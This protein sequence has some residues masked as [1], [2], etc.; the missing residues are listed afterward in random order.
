MP[1][2]QYASIQNPRQYRALRRRGFGKSAAARISNA[3]TAG[4]TV[5]APNYGAR[6]GQTIAGNLVRGSDGKFSSGSGGAPTTRQQQAAARRQTRQQRRDQAASA[7]DQAQAQEDTQRARE[8]AYVAGGTTGRERQ[9]RRREVAAARRKRLQARREAARQA[10]D[11]ERQQRSREEAGDAG[12][13]G[14]QVLRDRLAG[15]RQPKGG[16]G[17]GGGGGKKKPTDDEKRAEQLRKRAATA[18]ATAAQVGQDASFVEG[19]RAAAEGRLPANAATPRLSALGFAE[20]GE[21]TD[22]GRRALSALERGDVRGYQAAVQDARSARQRRE[23]TAA[24]RQATD[25]RRRAREHERAVRE[26]QRAVERAA[27]EAERNAR[28]AR[29]PLQVGVTST[30]AAPALPA[31]DRVLD[32]GHTGVM[33]ALFPDPAAVAAIT[34]AEGVTEPADQLHLTLAFLGDST[35]VPLATNKA[36][37]VDAVRSWAQ[38]SWRPLKGQVN[39]AGRFYNAESDGTNAIYLAPDVPGLPE[40]RQSLVAAIEAAGLDYASDHG[41]TPHMTIAYVPAD[42]PTPDV[43]VD[44]PVRFDRVTL[45]WGDE[46]YDFAG[47]AQ[48]AKAASAL[49]VFKDA[50]GRDRWIAI[51]TTAYEDRDGEIITVKGIAHAVAYGDQTGKRGTLRYWHVPGFDLGDCDYQAQAGPGGR[52]L[53]ESGTFYGEKEATIG[54]AMAAEGWQMSPGFLHPVT[55]PYPATVGGRRVGLFDH[56]MIFER[57]TTPPGR[58]SNLFGRFTTTKET[59]MT[60]EKQ[61]ALKALVGGD[62]QQLAALLGIINATDKGAQGQGVAYKE[63]PADPVAALQAQLAELQATVKALAEKA[64]PPAMLDAAPEAAGAEAPEAPE[65]EVELSGDGMEAEAPDDGP[66]LNDADAQIIAQAVVAAL[67]PMLEMEKK[68]RG[69]MDDMKGM[70]QGYGQKD[71]TRA[72]ELARTTQELATLKAHVAELRGEQPQAARGVGHQVPGEIAQALKAAPTGGAEA[73]GDPIASFLAG[74]A[75]LNG[76]ARG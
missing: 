55:E 52:F 40:L 68:M 36:R 7:R 18:T 13:A 39:G 12:V 58:A 33:V 60:E 47:V 63:A 76:A 67:A 74:F 17:G 49:A 75:S 1:G 26:Q 54:R 19:L 5:K 70:L 51:T 34:G 25:T 50:A 69:Y 37:V 35:E 46:Q 57:S 56:P 61:A 16:G 66:I 27:R 20:G 59:R 30:K 3:R 15:A 24:R 6:A 43:R 53:V 48:A 23:A 28:R 72:Q 45:A 73:S 44:L 65:V 41:F 31:P 10:R 9:A 22:Q 64:A 21:A 29:D 32:G 2:D 62:E 42:A 71:D 38:R 8:D 11:A 4:H 14:D